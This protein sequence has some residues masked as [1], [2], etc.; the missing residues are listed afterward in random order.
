[1]TTPVLMAVDDNPGGLGTLDGTLR[2][3]YGHDYLIISEASPESALGRLRELRAAGRPVALVMAAATMNAA[4]AA[5]VLAQARS[6]QPAAKLALGG[7]R[8]PRPRRAAPSRPPNGCWWSR[9]AA[10]PRPACAFPCRW[11]RTGRRPRR[12]CAR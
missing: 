7:P 1:M 4:P 2:S 6:V 11:Y 10:R 5:E 9:G 8:R 12:S 3:R